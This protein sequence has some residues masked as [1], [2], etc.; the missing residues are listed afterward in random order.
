MGDRPHGSRAKY[1]VE[2]CRC[3]LCRESTRVYEQERRKRTA[4][5]Y[6]GADRARQ[7]V[8][9]LGE[10]G[11]GLKRVVAVSG[12]SQGALWKLMYGK[13]RPDGTQVPSKRITREVE[14]KLLAVLPDAVADG[15]YVSGTKTR[16]HIDTLISRGWS[17]I[18]I[19]RHVHGPEARTLQV[20]KGDV[21]ARTARIIEGLLDL[22]VEQKRT[23]HHPD[24]ARII[25]LDPEADLRADA[26]REQLRLRQI[27][28]RQTGSTDITNVDADAMVANLDLAPLPEGIDLSWKRQATCRRPEFPT[29][30]FFPARGDT[31][32]LA[33]ARDAC[34]RCP[35]QEPCLDFALLT[36]A[37]GIWAGTSEKQRRQIRK[38]RAA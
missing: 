23:R 6:V 30:I 28:Y 18:A 16:R 12:V 5:A 1:V 29:W 25:P 9:W 17:R 10:Q 34:A 24:E 20:G 14:Q 37:D 32:T 7:H 19:G 33:A 13:R 15:A 38:E 2:K 22:P 4:P 27:Q 11:V 26:R 31:N 8:K 21:T 3:D 35:V 36:N